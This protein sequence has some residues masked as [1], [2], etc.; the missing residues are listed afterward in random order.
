MGNVTK[1]ERVKLIAG[2]TYRD[3]TACDAALKS[4][5]RRFGT[6][7]A[8]SP[9]FDFHQTKYYEPE[10]G[11]GLRKFFVSF[12]RLAAPDTLAEI[13][14]YTN[15][16]ERALSAAG[17]RRVNI[18]PGYLTLAKLVLATTKDFAHRIYIGKG[19]FAEV[20]LSYQEQAFRPLA[21]TYPD[22]RE[23]AYAAF[24]E[25]VRDRYCGQLKR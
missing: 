12:T 16:L 4:L 23:R 18:D 20:T 17:K 2:L 25:D 24:F 8:H 19:I 1:P 15:R 21:W 7:D 3:Q 22:Y 13:K 11:R 5:A 10:M 6:I 14:L 9:V